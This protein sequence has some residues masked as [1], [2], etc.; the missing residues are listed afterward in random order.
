MTNLNE[1][2][3]ICAYCGSV[4]NR[5]YIDEKGYR[6]VLKTT[7]CSKSCAV[8]IK[9]SINKE[10]LEKEILDF[11]SS[12]S[13]Y[14][15]GAEIRNGINRST[16]TFVQHG[17]KLIDLNGSLGFTKPKSKFQDRV[18]EV[19]SEEFSN[20]ESEKQFDG[21]VG[22]TGYPLRVDFFIPEK[23]IVVEADG[24]QHSDP[25]HPWSEWNNGTV[26]EYDKIKDQFFKEQGIRVCRI[27]YKRNLK[28][29]DVL[30]RLN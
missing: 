3:A 5:E 26:F 11:I 23:N 25:K 7:H 24:I 28:K 30:S 12:K 6:S 20:I 22:K 2:E 19:L 4:F 14:C 16:K 10:T 1:N 15:T 9:K 17:I 18:A 8:K 27:P 29:E 21:L 13:T